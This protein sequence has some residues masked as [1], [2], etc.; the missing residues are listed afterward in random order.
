[1]KN[2]VFRLAN[3]LLLF[4]N[5]KKFAVFFQKKNISMN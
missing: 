1:M 4:V 3:L 2:Y 5:T